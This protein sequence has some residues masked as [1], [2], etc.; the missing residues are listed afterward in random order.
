MSMFSCKTLVH[1]F[2][3]RLNKKYLKNGF[4]EKSLDTEEENIHYFDNQLRHKPVVIF[5]HGFGGDGKIT[6]REQ[7]KEM[8]EDYR[9][10][11]P[12]LLW[13]GK[14][15][16]DSDPSLMSQIT[17]VKSIIDAEGVSN[18]HL[19]G[20]SYG[21]FVSLGFAKK[22]E[23]Y[24][25]SLTIVDSPGA[26]M[27]ENEVKAFCQRVGAESV[28]DAFIPET[29]EE[30]ERLMNFVFKSPPF[31]TAGIRKETIGLYFSKFPEK[32][33]E[34]L[35]ELPDNRDWVAGN[36]GVPVLIL[37]GEDDEVFLVDE[38]EELKQMLNAKLIVIQDAGH[39]LPEEKPKQFNRALVD[40]IQQNKVDLN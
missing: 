10:I 33:A 5:I 16:S 17:M 32:Q 36:I 28:Q 24:L 18:V 39:S 7:V 26:A 40:F 20:I 27:S 38:A 8:H 30:V 35:S 29:E 4:I 2:D 14:S 12:D 11:V 21:G 31:L 25:S 37:W 15:N 1:K 34:L 22:H 23:K 19:V 13:F 6:W 3:E 9:I